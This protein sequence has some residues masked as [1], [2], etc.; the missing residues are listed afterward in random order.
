[1]RRDWIG[2]EGSVT[3][4]VIAL[5]AE[6]RGSAGQFQ[7]LCDLPAD[8]RPA[9]G[10][11]K[12]KRSLGTAIRGDALRLARQFAEQDDRTVAQ[13]RAAADPFSAPTSEQREAVEKAGG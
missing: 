13:L 9:L 1:M 12:W 3:P 11:T 10:K 4:A 8:F 6:G 7:R 5:R 2:I